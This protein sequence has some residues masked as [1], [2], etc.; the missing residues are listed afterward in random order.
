MRTGHALA[1][2]LAAEKN[3]SSEV[4]IIVPTYPPHFRLAIDLVRSVWLNVCS[5]RRVLTLLIVSASDE[6]PALRLLLKEHNALHWWVHVASLYD[7]DACAAE[8]SGDAELLVANATQF[9]HD[10]FVLQS[11]KKTL[12]ALCVGANVGAR[13]A[14]L[15]DS[16]S[17][18]TRRVDLE[19]EVRALHASV[20]PILFDAPRQNGARQNGG[21]R[22]RS[23]SAQLVKRVFARACESG[24]VNCAR[25]D[26]SSKTG[27]M[28]G[29]SLGYFWLFPTA[30]V[31]G[32]VRLLRTLHGSY[33]QAMRHIS[34]LPGKW[35]GELAL[36][37]YMLHIDADRRRYLAVD[38][39]TLL[40]THVPELSGNL[41]EHLWGDLLPRHVDGM[42][43]LYRSIGGAMPAWRVKPEALSWTRE[44]PV[45][46][47]A[48][49]AATHLE[50]LRRCKPIYLITSAQSRLFVAHA[51]RRRP[52]PLLS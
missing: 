34:T 23:E 5:S 47:M 37:V 25:W 7:V 9:R 24:T 46:G 22:S 35:F 20:R 21:A 14:L 18:V 40:R 17:L 6:K 1:V 26:A 11:S 39:Q 31:R 50:L 27:R 16:E 30:V 33:W 12:G 48:S 32:F 4:A 49:T 42:C 2:A 52:C 45:F 43:A 44:T 51:L 3:A 29:F 10:K 28:Y 38:V 13:H 8:V 15:L 36:F 19:A 41:T